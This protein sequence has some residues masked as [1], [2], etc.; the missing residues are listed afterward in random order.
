MRTVLKALIGICL[1]LGFLLLDAKAAETRPSKPGVAFLGFGADSD[2]LFCG[3]LT[4]DIRRD[5]SADTTLFTFPAASID[6]FFARGTLT[7]SEVSAFD[8][9]RLAPLGAQ[10]YAFAWLQPIAVQSTRKWTK[11]W[12]VKVRWSQ[13]LRLRVLDAGTGLPVFDGPV[14]AEI[15]EKA[16]LFGPDAPSATMAPVDRDRCYRRMLPLLSAQCAKQVS[17]VIAEK[18]AKPAVAAAEPSAA[19]AAGQ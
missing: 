11:F 4:R 14:P 5:L 16:L 8:L 7:G 12:D 13:S 9:P 15:A 17:Q 1:A 18:T 10:Y 3:Q 2:P 19:G 6:P